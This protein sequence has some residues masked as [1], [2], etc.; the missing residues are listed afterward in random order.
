MSKEPIIIA[1][2]GTSCGCTV[3]DYSKKL[4]LANEKSSITATY[5]AANV[6]AFTK[7][8]T[9]TFANNEIKVLNIKGTV[10]Q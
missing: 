6:G 9:V 2:V 8:I 5:D 7:A 4:I 3:A 1:T 10:V